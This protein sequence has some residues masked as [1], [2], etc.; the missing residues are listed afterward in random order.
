[1]LDVDLFI[2]AHGAQWSRLRA[3]TAQRRLTGSQVDELVAL[4]R[5]VSA[6]LA[7]AQEAHLDDAT[8]AMLA[9]L[10]FSARLRITR[11]RAGVWDTLRDFA[12]RDVPAAMYSARRWWGGVALAFLLVAASM[13]IWVETSPGARSAAIG[14]R[15]LEEYAGPGGDF[16]RYYSEHP[17]TFFGAH[18]WTNNAWVGVLALFTGVLIVPSVWVLFTN[19]MQLGL[20]GAV[21]SEAGRLDVFF[22][23]I[24]PHGMLELSCIFL[25]GAAGLR[26]GMAALAPG[27]RTRRAALTEAGRSGLLVAVGL[28]PFFFIAA[29]VEAFVT[30][31]GLPNV[32]RMVLGGCALSMLVAYVFL[33]GRRASESPGS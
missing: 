22:Y 26:M 32:I 21:M 8:V 2:V 18:V 31:S 10:V 7:R 6:Q 20:S 16:E 11:V 5:V 14:D 24:L 13:A 1:M 30:P 23:Y 17:A 4:Y 28:I 25:A 19:A 27:N 3:L 33:V 12:I 29:A 9:S 15:S